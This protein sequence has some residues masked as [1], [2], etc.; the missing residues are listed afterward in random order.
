MSTFK[1]K[2]QKYLTSLSKPRIMKVVLNVGTGRMKDR[3]EAVEQVENHLSMIAGQKA[4]P[5]PAKAAIASFKTRQG[6]V[7]G[8]KVTLRGQ[9]MFDFLDRLINLAIPRM[10]DFHGIPLKNID[11]NGNLTLGVREHIIFPE[12]TGENIRE[13]FGLEIT[14]VTSIGS[15]NDAIEAY[16]E[17]GFPL[18]K[19][20]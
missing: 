5:R 18:Q 20:D 15:R 1:E 12:V 2:Y 17:L 19:E 11:Q 10:R 9:K 3:K 13:I 16:K 7:V 6:M 8:Y 14:V 4:S